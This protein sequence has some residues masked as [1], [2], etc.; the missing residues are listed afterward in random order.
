MSISEF[1]VAAYRKAGVAA[2]LCRPGV[3]PNVFFRKPDADRAAL[4][5]KLGLTPDQFIVG[6][7]AMNQGRKAISLMLKAFFEFC[8][9]K[10]DTRYLLDM[11]ATS[12]AGWD[13]PALC[14]QYGWDKSRLLFRADAARAGLTLADRYNILDAHMVISHREGYGLPLAEAMACGAVSMAMD[15]C[16]GAEIVG[17]GKGVLIP[18]VEGIAEPGTWGGAEDRWPN[19]PALVKALDNLYRNPIERAAIAQR[20]QEWARS[21]TWDEAANAVY[22]TLMQ[23]VAK[24]AAWGMAVAA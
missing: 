5:A 15:Y 2:N 21:H 4:R 24:R 10:P 3:D 17:G 7:M 13:I 14:D 8:T 23:A 22:D 1:G 16:S 19:M 20:G 9:D 12:P 6:T 11:E 18:C